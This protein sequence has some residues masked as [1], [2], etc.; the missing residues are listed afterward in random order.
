VFWSP[1]NVQLI[2]AYYGIQGEFIFAL[3]DSADGNIS[4]ILTST[5]MAWVDSN[6]F[7]YVNDDKGFFLA[8]TDGKQTRI[9]VGINPVRDFGTVNAVDGDEKWLLPFDSLFHN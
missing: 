4:S 2:R 5:T 7:V 9:D 8:S 1:D 6:R 3:I